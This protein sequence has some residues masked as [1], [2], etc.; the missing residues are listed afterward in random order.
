MFGAVSIRST[1]FPALVGAAW[2]I[3]VASGF[4]VLH[5]YASTP[6][7]VGIVP[8]S[9]PVQDRIALEVDR[10]TLIV[11]IHPRCPCTRATALALEELLASRPGQARLNVLVYKPAQASDS[12][13]ASRISRSLSSLPDAQ[14]WIDADGALASRFG[15]VTS[16]QVL[17]FDAHGELCFSGGVT[18]VR[19][20]VGPNAGYAA[21]ASLL[22]HKPAQQKK[23]PVFGCS[24]LSAPSGRGG[25]S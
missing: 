22:D 14:S 13:A 16:G 24:I 8:S 1:L 6:A 20:Q 4:A 21:L 9:W 23:F 5:R 18:P 11:A 7:H 10:L 15:A 3:A 12:W 25:K 19:G 17:A 2:L